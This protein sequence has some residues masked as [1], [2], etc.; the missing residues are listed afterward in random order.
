MKYPIEVITNGDKIEYLLKLQEA[1]RLDHNEKGQKF[2]NG[3]ISE[4]E[5]L[6]YKRGEHE[7]KMNKLFKEQWFVKEAMKASTRFVPDI[8]KD[9][10]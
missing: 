9:F 2:K 6:S 10:E 4:E 8:N 7:I 1:M 3:E 5:W